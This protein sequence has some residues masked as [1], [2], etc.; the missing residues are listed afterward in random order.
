MDVLSERIYMNIE[1]R[2]KGINGA[3]ESVSG[4]GLG[5]WKPMIS[6]ITYNYQR[7]NIILES[8]TLPAGI[9]SDSHN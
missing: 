1:V 7:I 2:R 5:G 3:D 9:S 4:G 6:G 8:S